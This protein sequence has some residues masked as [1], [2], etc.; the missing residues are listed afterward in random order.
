MPVRVRPRAPRFLELAPI[1]AGPIVAEPWRAAAQ[2]PAGQGPPLESDHNSYLAGGYAEEFGYDAWRNGA[3]ALPTLAGEP[4]RCR[5]W[6]LQIEG[7]HPGYPLC[8]R[9]VERELASAEYVESRYS[10]RHSFEKL[11]TPST[12][13]YI[14]ETTERRATDFTVVRVGERSGRA[15]RTQTQAP[16]PLARLWRELRIRRRSLGGFF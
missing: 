16:T 8:A 14:E 15:A 5:E 13:Q 10:L 4:E 2:L 6:S 1:A 3:P 12:P 9:P 11:R 7:L